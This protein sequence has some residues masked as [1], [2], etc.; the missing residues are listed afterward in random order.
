[1]GGKGVGARLGLVKPGATAGRENVSF[2]KARAPAGAEIEAAELGYDRGDRETFAAGWERAERLARELVNRGCDLVVVSGTPPFL[3]EGLAFERRWRRALSKRIG[4]PVVTAMEAHAMALQALGA[5]RVA[6]ATYYGNELNEAVARYLG[7]FDIEAELLG[8]F[9]LT[10]E[11][12]GLFSTPMHAQATITSR[13]VYDY[14]YQG[15]QDGRDDVDALYINGAGWDVAAIITKLEQDLHA[16]VVWGPVAEMWLSYWML[17][18]SN[19]Q[20]DCGRLLRG[21]GVVP[22]SSYE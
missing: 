17:G 21:E 20:P 9:S 22:L 6:V 2:W 8:G 15:V 16:D 5:S 13:Q 3:L 18:I 11:G 10:G 14:C 4:L 7:H 1:V 12:E 19:E